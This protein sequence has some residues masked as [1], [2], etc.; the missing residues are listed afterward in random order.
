MSMPY[1]RLSGWAFAR[2]LQ[3]V[4][5]PTSANGRID[6]PRVKGAIHGT[7]AAIRPKV[8]V[9]ARYQRRQRICVI[10]VNVTNVVRLLACVQWAFLVPAPRYA[11]VVVCI[12]GV[13]RSCNKLVQPLPDTPHGI[14]N[15]HGRNGIY[16]AACYASACIAGGAP[17]VCIC[18]IQS[19]RAAKSISAKLRIVRQAL[20]SLSVR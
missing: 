9:A 12:C 20:T 14:Y 7:S 11:C 16:H 13:F 15:A 2:R 1:P 19:G 3:R 18:V 5:R 6:I 8:P 4:T 10:L 17:C